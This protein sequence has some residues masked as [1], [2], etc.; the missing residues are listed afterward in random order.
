M[1]HGE[2]QLLALHLPEAA[3]L[4]PNALD[5]RVASSLIRN[6]NYEEEVCRCRASYSQRK[7]RSSSSRMRRHSSPRNSF[8]A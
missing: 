6:G 4:F 7:P 8:D 2:L 5:N 3:Q 1:R